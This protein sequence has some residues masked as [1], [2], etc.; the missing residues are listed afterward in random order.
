VLVIREVI[1]WVDDVVRTR[2]KSVSLP[3]QTHPIPESE[4][5]IS[6]PQRTN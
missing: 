2:Q 1:P 3:N 6:A 5:T 4:S